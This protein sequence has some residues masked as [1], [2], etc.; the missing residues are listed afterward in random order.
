MIAAAGA[1]WLTLSSS[2][3]AAPAGSEYLPAVPKGSGKH[4]S[5]GSSQGSASSPSYDSS[6]DTSSGGTTYEPS[7]GAADEKPEKRKP[8]P[9]PKE[10]AP[11]R[12]VRTLTPAEV[13]SGGAPWALLGIILVATTATVAGGLALRRRTA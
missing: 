5:G 1:L 4:D 12:P 7:G 9:E 2:A 8:K 13:D 10:A 6:S 11:V 3:A